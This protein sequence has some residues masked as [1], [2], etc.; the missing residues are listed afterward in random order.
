MNKSSF[1]R[2]YF[3]IL[4]NE[5]AHENMKNVDF[6][7]TDFRNKCQSVLNRDGGVWNNIVSSYTHISIK[8]DPTTS[9]YWLEQSTIEHLRFAVGW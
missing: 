6:F 1:L 5:S 3:V 4:Y 7:P 9:D 8:W 2:V